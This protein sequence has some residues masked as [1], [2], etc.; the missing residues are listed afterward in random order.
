M[1]ERSEVYS[2]VLIGS[3]VQSTEYIME[4]NAARLTVDIITIA[5][6]PE[7]LQ[8]ICILHNLWKQRG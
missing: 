7:L 8:I 1:K 3:F 4:E 5:S 6:F 2:Q